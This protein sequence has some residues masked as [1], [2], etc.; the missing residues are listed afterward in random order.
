MDSYPNPTAREGAIA[1]TTEGERE[2]GRER[3]RVNLNFS[4]SFMLQ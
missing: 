2:R 4:Q 1:M 3:E